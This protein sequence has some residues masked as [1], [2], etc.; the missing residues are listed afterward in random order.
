MVEMALVLPLYLL[1]LTGILAFGVALGNY[2]VLTNATAAGAQL[3]SISRGLPAAANP[4]QTVANAVY[5]ASPYLTPASFTFSL[6]FNGGTPLTGA[7]C[8]AGAADMVQGASAQLTA[9]Y[10]CVL[11]IAGITYS[12]LLQASTTEIIQ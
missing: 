1:L 4:C 11:A 2:L 10:P 12:C 3:L 9:T 7:S 6:S 5:N 8:T